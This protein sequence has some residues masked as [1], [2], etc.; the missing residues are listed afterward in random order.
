MANPQLS[1]IF[2][3]LH[4]AL[5]A[6]AMLALLAKGCLG[7]LSGLAN[8]LPHL[9]NLHRKI[10]FT[11]DI[12]RDMPLSLRSACISEDSEGDKRFPPVKLIHYRMVEAEVGKPLGEFESGRDL[13]KYIHDCVVAHDDAVNIARILHRDISSGNMLMFPL[14]CTYVNGSKRWLW[15]GLLNDWELS[16]PIA[17]PGTAAEARRADRTGTWQFMSKSI[18]TDKFRAPT[19]Q[20]ELES[21]FYVLLYFGV[22]FSN[23]K[24]LQFSGDDRVAHNPFNELIA[25]MLSWFHGR[26]FV[27]TQRRRPDLS[28]GG[29]LIQT[30]DSDQLPIDKYDIVGDQTL[31]DEDEDEPP[32]RPS[33]LPKNLRGR[34]LP[35][36]RLLRSWM[37]IAQYANCCQKPSDERIGQSRT[38]L[39]ISCQRTIVLQGHA[40]AR[41]N[42]KMRNGLGMSLLM[43]TRSIFR[44]NVAEEGSLQA[45]VFDRWPLCYRRRTRD[46]P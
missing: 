18:L 17:Q 24:E 29:T 16:K 20:D 19:V 14:K 41:T 7:A 37:D 10:K 5:E 36:R 35:G 40:R 22:T 15:K 38:N 42:P 30:P 27:E 2:C 3:K 34:S 6:F 46:L 39:E 26:Y 11:F 12:W 23:E 8:S 1:G 4:L 45:S 31:Q 21:F 43:L 9:S 13:V 44:G 32:A 25:T 33:N 28:S